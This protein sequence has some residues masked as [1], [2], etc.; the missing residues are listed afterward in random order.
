L[1]KKVNQETRCE[2]QRTNGDGREFRSSHRWIRNEGSLFENS[3]DTAKRTFSFRFILI[4]C[5]LLRGDCDRRFVADTRIQ[6]ALLPNLNGIMFKR[7]QTWKSRKHL[8]RNRR[9][10][11]MSAPTRM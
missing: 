3:E 10:V 4:H 2:R 5:N 7:E 6:I 1:Q 8:W 11:A 9:R